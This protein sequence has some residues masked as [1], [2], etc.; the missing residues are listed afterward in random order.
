MVKDSNTI[1]LIHLN[2]DNIPKSCRVKFNGR[3]SVMLYPKA[4]QQTSISSKY[5]LGLTH[6]AITWMTLQITANEIHRQ[7][8][9]NDK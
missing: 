4:S 9:M 7:T 5:I 2:Q 1:A 6:E 3:D 8:S